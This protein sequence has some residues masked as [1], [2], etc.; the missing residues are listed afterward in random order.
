MSEQYLENDNSRL[1][2]HPVPPQPFIFIDDG[3]YWILPYTVPNGALEVPLR[4]EKNDEPY[5]GIASSPLVAQ[6]WRFTA[7]PN[8]PRG[9]YSIVSSASDGEGGYLKISWTQLSTPDPDLIGTQSRVR[10]YPESYTSNYA[11][12]T[13]ERAIPNTNIYTIKNEMV[14]N[15]FITLNENQRTVYIDSSMVG[16]PQQ[17]WVLRPVT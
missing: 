12:W 5:V 17:M 4:A 3:L 13:L 6:I 7:N 16:T 8:A 14:R 10:L 1:H 2:P 15:G 9:M 11:Y